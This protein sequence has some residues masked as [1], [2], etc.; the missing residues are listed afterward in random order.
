MRKAVTVILITFL[1]LIIAGVSILFIMLLNGNIRINELFNFNLKKSYIKEIAVDE[2]YDN[3]FDSINIYTTAG[4]IN[5]YESST[6]E[7]QLVVYNKK[8]KTTVEVDN[9]KL[10]IKA[11]AKKC[12]FLCIN[13][14]IAKI[15]LYIPSNYDKE[16]K[17]TTEYGDVK[18]ESFENGNFEIRSNYGDIKIDK[19]N[20]AK[21]DLDYG[22]IRIGTINEL[23]VDS[24]YGDIKIDTINSYF[25]IN[26]DYGDIK[27]DSA[28]LTKDSKIED[29]FG[30][31]KIKNI[32]GVYIDAKTD[33]GD[34]DT[35]GNDRTSTITLTIR[36]DYGDIEVN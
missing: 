31:I 34:V 14:K 29:D 17:I 15:E 19:A 35:N 11:K 20:I 26:C 23:I 30:D 8:D 25:K 9:N 1:L 12:H 4:E 5:I 3:T 24:N 36:T 27:I 16:I 21:T 33:M 32:S 28:S 18:I 13:P 2:T 6:E 10:D 22:D 7:I